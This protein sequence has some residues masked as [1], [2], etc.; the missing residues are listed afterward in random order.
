MSFGEGDES[1][2]MMIRDWQEGWRRGY[3]VKGDF[4]WLDMTLAKV[5]CAR[6]EKD[7]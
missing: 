5:N 7:M 2:E 3:V 6:M 4:S 1:K